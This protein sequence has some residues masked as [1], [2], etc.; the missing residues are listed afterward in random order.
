MFECD[1]CGKQF[2]DNSKFKK[3]KIKTSNEELIFNYCPICFDS[4]LYPKQVTNVFII[5]NENLIEKE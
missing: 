3:L 4:F 5:S 2:T 1:I